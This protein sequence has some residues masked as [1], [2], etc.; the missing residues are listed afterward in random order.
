MNVSKGRTT[1]KQFTFSE[2]VNMIVNGQLKEPNVGELNMS[3]KELVES[4]HPLPMIYFKM[5]KDG[6]YELV[7]KTSHDI[8]QTL[9]CLCLIASISSMVRK[10]TKCLLTVIIFEPN[11][12]Q[13][14]VIEVYTEAGFL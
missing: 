6:K 1:V 10:Y 9:G 7:G 12:H 3:I 5:D 8:I 2:I 4:E 13:D 14:S 11:E